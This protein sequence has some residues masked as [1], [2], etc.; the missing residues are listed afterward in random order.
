MA[1]VCAG[2]FAQKS[3]SLFAAS[4]IDVVYPFLSEKMF[5]LALASG[6]WEGAAGEPKWLLKAALAR[7]VPH[8]MVYRRKCAFVAPIA[9]KFRHAAFLAAFEKLATGASPISPFVH[10]GFFRRLQPRIRAGE[11]LPAQ[12]AY[13]VWSTVFIS[14]WLQQISESRIG[15]AAH[16]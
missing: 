3:R 6:N 12:T 5:Q 8:E 7:H 15:G 14:E 1:L 4:E 2:I 10:D 11:D 9:Q 16:A 13:F